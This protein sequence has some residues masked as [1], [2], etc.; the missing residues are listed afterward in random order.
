[1]IGE[2]RNVA[3]RRVDDKAA[4]VQPARGGRVEPPVSDGALNAVDGFDAD[5]RDGQP[6]RSSSAP[7]PALLRP[8]S[9]NLGLPP[10]AGGAP[11][12]AT[13]EISPQIDIDADS[14][15]PAEEA[16]GSDETRRADVDSRGNWVPPILR[17]L[18]PD[19]AQAKTDLPQ[20]S[21]R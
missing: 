2:V 1:M 21:R 14:E 6:S 11:G 10:T 19:A 3:G 18:A 5:R 13:T 15:P 8:G 7:K 4:P 17:G 9:S 12:P 16:E 20:R